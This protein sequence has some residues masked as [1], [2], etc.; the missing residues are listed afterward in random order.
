LVRTGSRSGSAR[1]S[2][3]P[4][5][6]PAN[7][8]RDTDLRS[9]RFLAVDAYPLMEVVADRIGLTAGG[10]QADAV[11]R[12]HGCEA[13]LRIDAALAGAGTAPRLR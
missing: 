13:P 12:A 4:R 9:K 3:P 10:W 11:L 8:R 6:V 7:S 5:S 2:T 1:R